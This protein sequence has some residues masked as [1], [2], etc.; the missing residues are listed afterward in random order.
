MCWVVSAAEAGETA[1]NASEVAAV[2]ENKVVEARFMA[3]FFPYCGTWVD[4]LGVKAEC[5]TWV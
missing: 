2:S 1:A 4:N 3:E 5:E